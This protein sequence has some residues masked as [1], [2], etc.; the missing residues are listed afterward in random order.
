ML[1]ASRRLAVAA[2]R[3]VEARAGRVGRVGD[4]RRGVA[5]VRV[6]RAVRAER[7]ERPVRREARPVAAVVGRREELAVHTVHRVVKAA[8]GEVRA[9]GP[10][11]VAPRGER[12]ELVALLAVRHLDRNAPWPLHGGGVASESAAEAKLARAARRASVGVAPVARECEIAAQVRIV[13]QLICSVGRHAHLVD[14]QIRVPRATVGARDDANL[15][16]ADVK[17]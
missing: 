2:R 12:I 15:A 5:R 10:V 1:R 14:G 13:H 11:R 16:L 6:E 7:D 8:D 17:A 4:R 9:G 3:T